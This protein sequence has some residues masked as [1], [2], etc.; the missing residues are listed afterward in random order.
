MSAAGRPR[1]RVGHLGKIVTILDVAGDFVAR[2]R[3][4]D[5]DGALRKVSARGAT[6]KEAEDNLVD[7]ARVRVLRATGVVSQ[8]STIGD[9]VDM[10]LE[11]IS[12]STRYAVQTKA[13]YRQSS[14][15]IRKKFGGLTIL[16]LTPGKVLTFIEDLSDDHLSE[17]R[18]ARVVLKAIMQRALRSDV[19]KQ[20]PVTEAAVE[21]EVP[22]SKPRAITEDDLERLRAAIAGWRTGTDV[23][24][25]KP[26]P[27]LGDLLEVMLGT[28]TRISEALAIRAEDVRIGEDGVLRVE[29]CG[30]IIWEKGVGTYRQPIPKSDAGHRSPV[31]YPAGLRCRH[32]SSTRALWRV[33]P[34]FCNEAWDPLPSAELRSDA[35]GDR[36]RYGP[37]L[38]HQPHLPEDQRDGHRQARWQRQPEEGLTRTRT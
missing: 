35:P 22:K 34:D 17:A 14:K 16:E 32:H 10:Y 4:R 20:N 38:D 36:R 21:L 5:S 6:E 29:I 11:K 12:A 26:S 19:I 13:R 30:T 3:I 15:L 18:T 24:G 28:T 8:D 37:R 25:P 31:H 1:T 27:D 7:L 9:L 23:H 2:S 33:E